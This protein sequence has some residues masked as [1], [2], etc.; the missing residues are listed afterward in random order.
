MPYIVCIVVPQYK[1]FYLKDMFINILF[2]GKMCNGLFTS[3]V[4]FIGD[5]KY[6]RGIV[7]HLDSL[8]VT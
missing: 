3:P 4:L 6:F 5:A 7:Y 8:D 1:F 2:T